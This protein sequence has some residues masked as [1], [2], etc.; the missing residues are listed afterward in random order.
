MSNLFCRN[1]VRISI[2]GFHKIADES[3]SAKENVFNNGD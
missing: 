2:K 3:I 1:E